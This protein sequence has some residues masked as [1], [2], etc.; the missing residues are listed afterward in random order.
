MDLKC[1]NSDNL[2]IEMPSIVINWNVVFLHM[3]NTLLVTQSWFGYPGF[4][5]FPNPLQVYN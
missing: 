2:I 4:Q 3:T 5:C 1:Q